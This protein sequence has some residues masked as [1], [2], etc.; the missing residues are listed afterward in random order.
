MILVTACTPW[1]VEYLQEVEGKATQDQIAQRLG[2]PRAGHKLNNGGEVWTY[3][4]CSSEVYG[5][6]YGVYGG[7][8]CTEYVLTFDE[9]GILRHWVRQ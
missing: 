3:E 4:Y 7:G 8:D 5:N 2:A 1:R 6:A 9:R